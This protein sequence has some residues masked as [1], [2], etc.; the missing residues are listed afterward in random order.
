MGGGDRKQRRGARQE[1]GSRQYVPKEGVLAGADDTKDMQSFAAAVAKSAQLEVDQSNGAAGTLP[2]S[3]L[4]NLPSP[5]R[6]RAGVPNAPGP[7]AD[8][9][10]QAE[11]SPTAGSYRDQ[12][13]ANG[14]RA[15]QRA[16]DYGMMPRPP[17]PATGPLDTAT[18][19]VSSTNLDVSSGQ[20]QYV[21]MSC[22]AAGLQ[23]WA[24]SSASSG[25]FWP[26]SGMDMS[27]A[28]QMVAMQSMMMPLT[29][30]SMASS[31]ADGL[32]AIAMPQY[33]C[34]MNGEQLAAQLRAAAPVCYED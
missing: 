12:L 34:D 8:P 2:A 15:L 16:W 31:P 28:S 20:D 32:M 24:A 14:Q 21:A 26:E 7:E 4:A 6:R 29:P 5:H 30:S 18:L 9:I 10:G 13:R 11:A 17:P 23:P 3:E 22:T 33:C 1:K 19:G 27:Q 25:G